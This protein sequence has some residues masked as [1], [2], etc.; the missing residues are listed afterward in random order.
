MKISLKNKRMFVA[1][2][3]IGI[4][5]LPGAVKGFQNNEM[6][7]GIK[8]LLMSVVMVLVGTLYLL[9]AKKEERKME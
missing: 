1:F 3:V 8:C 2:L 6:F 7:E 4:L 9:P 5:F